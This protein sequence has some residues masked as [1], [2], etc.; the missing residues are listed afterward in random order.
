MKQTL[1]IVQPMRIC[2]TSQPLDQRPNY[3]KNVYLLKCDKSKL[4]CLQRSNTQ[5]NA[6]FQYKKKFILQYSIHAFVL[7]LFPCMHV[8]FCHISGVHRSAKPLGQILVQCHQMIV[9][10]PLCLVNLQSFTFQKWPSQHS[11]KVCKMCLRTHT[12]T[13]AHKHLQWYLISALCSLHHPLSYFNG[14]H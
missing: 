7:H 13:D 9:E 8:F 5:T 10:V 14:Q 1:Q 12:H 4:L 11:M 2:S 6:L 3:W